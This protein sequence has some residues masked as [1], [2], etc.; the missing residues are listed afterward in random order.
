MARKDYYK[1]LGVDRNASPEEIRRAYRTLAKQYHPDVSDVDDG[2]ERFREITAAYE[3]LKDP[4]NRAEYD[5]GG[6]GGEGLLW[7][8]GR[9]AEQRRGP[10]VRWED[11]LSMFDDISGFGFSSRPRPSAYSTRS[12]ADR[13]TNRYERVDGI[14]I[15]EVIVGLLRAVRHAAYHE[16]EYII[17]KSNHID[18]FATPPL[19]RIKRE[20]ESVYIEFSMNVLYKERSMQRLETEAGFSWL[21]L[22]IFGE[23]LVGEQPC[24]YIRELVRLIVDKDLSWNFSEDELRRIYDLGQEVRLLTDIFGDGKVYSS[25][26]L[27]NALRGVDRTIQ[28]EGDR[29]VLDVYDEAMIAMYIACDPH[30]ELIKTDGY[31]NLVLAE[32]T[33]ETD[34]MRPLVVLYRERK[35]GERVW[36]PRVT[37]YFPIPGIEGTQEDE[38]IFTEYKRNIGRIASCL[39]REEEVPAD[40][41][42]YFID[43]SRR[44][45]SKRGM[46]KEWTGH[47]GRF[48]KHG[49]RDYI[50]RL[51]QPSTMD[52]GIRQELTIGGTKDPI[53]REILREGRLSRTWLGDITFRFGNWDIK[54]WRD[55]E[56]RLRGPEAGY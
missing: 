19:F 2:G 6:W 41:R 49:L 42:L 47:K 22:D 53:S 27:K 11:F 33:S 9:R 35:N 44:R 26:E 30:M 34:L 50:I 1:V 46:S 7:S 23:D 29:L 51:F 36:R 48:K 13:Q 15:P 17:V 8:S 37:P 5:R 52:Y 40:L 3:V 21:R 56:T 10:H 55:E 38:R 28:V 25:Y 4:G 24:G 39:M 14:Y 18:G 16:G 32:R 12:G 31:V 43:L 45:G 54:T 20:G